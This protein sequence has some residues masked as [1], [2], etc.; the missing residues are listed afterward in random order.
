MIIGQSIYQLVVTFVLYFAGGRILNYDLSD[1]TKKLELDTII[2]N[3]F[4]WMQIFNEF[5][6]RR[7][8]NK[9]NIFVGIHRNYFFI[10]INCIMVGLQIGIIYVGSRAFQIKPGGLDAVQWA[11]SVI[12]A[13]LCLPWAIAIRFFPDTWFAAIASVVG[14]P[15]VVVYRGLGKV[16]LKVKQIFKRNKVQEIDAEMGNTPIVNVSI[17][18]A[19][20]EKF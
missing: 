3:C 18:V 17:D 9:L 11:I 4:V 2:F 10:V 12:T 15:V 19:S 20:K 6:N 8:D 13:S 7:L 14:K 5:N 1:P 16:S